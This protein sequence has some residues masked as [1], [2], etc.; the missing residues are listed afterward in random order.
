MSSDKTQAKTPV[1]TPGWEAEYDLVRELL[2][3]KFMRLRFPDRLEEDLRERMLRRAVTTLRENYWMLFLL[4]V[5]TVIIILLEF[6]AAG[7]WIGP[8]EDLRVMT[9]VGCVSGVTLVGMTLAGKTAA[10]DRYYLLY[11]TPVTMALLTLLTVA[12]AFLLDETLRHSSTYVIIYVLL[13]LY[14]V[15]NMPLSRAAFIGLGSMLTSG[16]LVLFLGVRFDWSSFAQY[17][18]ITNL[19]G[20]GNGYV[21][22]VRERRLFL[23]SRLIEL[24]K[25]QLN[26]LSERLVQLSREDGLTGLANR[27]HFNDTFLLEWERARRER[28]SLALVFADVDHFKAYNDNHGHIEG[29][30]AL[31]AVAAVMQRVATRP[32]DLAARYGGEEFV[33][34]LPNTDCHGAREV[35]EQLLRAVD[36]K[37]LPHRASSVGKHVSI[38]IGVAAIVPDVHIAPVQLIDRADTALYQAKEAGRHRVVVSDFC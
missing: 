23:Q 4:A 33:L 35:A 19:V 12:P 34:L 30:R 29:D 7:H 1:K 25:R 31:A 21:L 38:S 36:A 13:I 10:L 9:F 5:S 14:G 26:K 8:I 24:E 16:L 22:E 32:G 6:T 2:A 17:F 15:S 11:V 20:I 37:A 27:R 3:Q 18:L 28:H